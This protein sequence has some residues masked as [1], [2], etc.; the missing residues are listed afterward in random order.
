MC[1]NPTSKTTIKWEKLGVTGNSSKKQSQHYKDWS[2]SLLVRE[3]IADQYWSNTCF[4]S[5]IS[6]QQM[7]VA[8]L[9]SIGYGFGRCWFWVATHVTQQEPQ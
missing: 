7:C 3:D 9:A 1:L 4:L 5:D 8:A 6:S 2:E